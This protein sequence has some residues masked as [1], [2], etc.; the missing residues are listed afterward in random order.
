MKRLSYCDD[1][2]ARWNLPACRE[3]AY[4]LGKNQQR[5]AYNPLD[6]IGRVPE[7]RVRRTLT[8]PYAPAMAKAQR[9]GEVGALILLSAADK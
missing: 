2:T 5:C 8:L 9:R 7:V 1:E 6:Q 4:L 3:S